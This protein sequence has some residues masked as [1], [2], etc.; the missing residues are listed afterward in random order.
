MR[1][2]LFLG[3]AMV[4]IASSA[5]AQQDRTPEQEAREAAESMIAAYVSTWNA[6][7]AEGISKLYRD[8]GVWLTPVGTVLTSRE[9]IKSQVAARMKNGQPK[10]SEKLIE[11]HPAGNNVWATGEWTLM[12]TDGHEVSGHFAWIMVPEGHNWLLRMQISK[13]TPPH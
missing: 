1:R 5:L 6:G 13:I 2:R 3:I 8:D 9:A 10:L 12:P 11:A 4:C 7:D